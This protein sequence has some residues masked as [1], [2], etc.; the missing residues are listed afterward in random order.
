[1]Q[2]ARHKNSEGH[3]AR[4][5]PRSANGSTAF[6]P[7]R[8][9]LVVLLA[10]FMLASPQGNTPAQAAK[11]RTVLS[12][13]ERL[14]DAKALTP[15]AYREHRGT[16]LDAKRLLGKLS[17]SRRIGMRAPLV[18]LERIAKAGSLTSGRVPALMLTVQRNRQAW[19]CDPLP[20][21]GQRRTFGASQLVWQ[22]YLGQGWQIQWLATFGKA[23][24]LWSFKKKDDELRALL[25][26]AVALAA[27]RAG[28]IAWEYLFAFG[29][30]SPPWASGMAQAT[31]IQ[32]LSRAAVRLKEPAYF[33]AARS[34]LGIFQT[35]PPAGVRVDV[36]PG[37]SHYLLYSYARGQRVLNGFNQAVNGLHDFAT[38][39]NDA[40]GRELYARGVKQLAAELPRYDTGGWSRYQVGGR[41][42]DVGYHKLARDFLRGLCERTRADRTRASAAQSGGATPEAPGGATPAQPVAPPPPAERAPVIVVD[43]E[44]FCAFATRMTEDLQRPPRLDIVTTRT[45][46]GKRGAVRVRVDKP[47]TVTVTV[48][49]GQ[50]TVGARTATVQPGSPVFVYA[51]KTRA[52]RYLVT[53]R[54][55]DV[56]GLRGATSAVLT[57]ARP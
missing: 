25:D 30:G 8:L 50:K 51:N 37:R 33:E 2:S 27:P 45:R 12:E 4:G 5:R 17:G 3:W 55:T 46:A 32:S 40:E 15:A 24:A 14:R 44:P 6:L 39:A 31:G 21:N 26:E 23:N 53:V 18:H 52:G 43:P 28:G 56:V 22:H 13:L 57:I 20:R 34:A 38:L 1:M 36:A 41:A 10:G 48:S 49:R 47:A 7:I 35:K 54:A 11:Q 29:G 16:Y 42:S 9:V 19:C